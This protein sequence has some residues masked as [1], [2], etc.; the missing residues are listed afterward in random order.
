VHAQTRINDDVPCI[1]LFANNLFVYLGFWRYIYNKRSFNPR[2][3]AEAPVVKRA[4]ARFEFR[5][6]FT[7]FGQA[8]LRRG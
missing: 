6:G 4:F 2:M 7:K 5:F 8:G 3:A 1:D